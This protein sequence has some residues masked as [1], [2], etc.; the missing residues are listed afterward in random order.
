[1]FGVIKTN[2]GRHD[3]VSIDAMIGDM[4]PSSVKSIPQGAATQVLLCARPEARDAHGGYCADCQPRETS[5][6]GRDDELAERLWLK[7]EELAASL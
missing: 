5:E 7:S 3:Q 1:M 2:L 6:R 4:D